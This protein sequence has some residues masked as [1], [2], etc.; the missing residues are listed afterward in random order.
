MKHFLIKKGK[1]NQH[2]SNLLYSKM[3]DAWNELPKISQVW[4]NIYFSSES[5]KKSIEKINILSEILLKSN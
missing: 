3:I 4:L 5:N 2:I 1:L